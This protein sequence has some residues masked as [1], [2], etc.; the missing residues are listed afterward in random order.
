MFRYNVANTRFSIDNSGGIRLRIYDPNF[1]P[2]GWSL[3]IGY[4][5]IWG[6]RCNTIWWEHVYLNQVNILAVALGPLP[7]NVG[8]IPTPAN[9]PSPSY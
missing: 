3:H 7:R 6:C 4:R 1:Y 5:L 2:R 8:S 9:N